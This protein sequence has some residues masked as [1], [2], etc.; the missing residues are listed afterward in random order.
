MIRLDLDG[1]IRDQRVVKCISTCLPL[2]RC[3]VQGFARG[4]AALAHR[5]SGVKLSRAQHRDDELSTFLPTSTCWMMSTLEGQED[6]MMLNVGE[7]EEINSLTHITRL[8]RG[9]TVRRMQATLLIV[10]L[11]A[12][13]RLWNLRPGR[14]RLIHGHPIP[15]DWSVL[16]V[17]ADD[18][19]YARYDSPE[20]PVNMPIVYGWLPGTPLQR[21]LLCIC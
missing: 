12:I 3:R 2:G 13:L 9:Y 17:A 19:L 1:E 8:G 15:R 11:Q 21:E 6:D 16:V 14:L 5:T 7:E 10:H 4:A 20:F 18:D